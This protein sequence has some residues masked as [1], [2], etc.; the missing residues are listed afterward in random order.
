VNSTPGAESAGEYGGGS[1]FVEEN[2]K[3]QGLRLEVREARDAFDRLKEEA[4]QARVALSKAAEMVGARG[5]EGGG[6][7]Q[8]PHR[9]VTGH[10]SQGTRHKAPVTSDCV[11]AAQVSHKSQVTRH[12]S[13]TER[14]T[15]TETATET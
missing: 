7:R 3:V 11:M 1:S 14:G 4:G 13:E 8:W 15:E 2:E 9:L 5:D 6:A 10:K 12:K